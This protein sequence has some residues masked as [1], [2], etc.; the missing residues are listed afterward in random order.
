M[1]SFA[2]VLVY[3]CIKYSGS[4]AVSPDIDKALDNYFLNFPEAQVAR[5]RVLDAPHKLEGLLKH[6]HSAFEDLKPLIRDW[7]AVIK[8]AFEFQVGIEFN[9]PHQI[10]LRLI[11]ETLTQINDTAINHEEVERR[12]QWFREVAEAVKSQQTVPQPEITYTEKTLR[13]PRTDTGPSRSSLA[14]HSPTR[15]PPSKRR[16]T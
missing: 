4:G 6:M 11:D 16:R 5:L 12:N 15:S 13:N 1:E 7:F 14:P 9:Y 3:L 2:W 10:I 8:V